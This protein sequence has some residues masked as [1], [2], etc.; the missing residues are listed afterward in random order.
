VAFKAEAIV[1]PAD[2]PAYLGVGEHAGRVSDLAYHNGL[3]V[4]VWSMLASGEVKVTKQ[5]KL[6]NVLSSG[7][8]FGE[9]AY[10]SPERG[11]RMAAV[12]AMGEG[13]VIVVG[14]EA[15]AQATQNTRH[16][17]DRAFLR[18]LVDRLDLANTRLTS[19][20]L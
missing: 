2:L 4:Q 16:Q 19:L 8:C 9:M 18:I 12:S 13:L 20:A 14:T 15:L 3:M 6:L 5:N 7:E 11:A 10:L 1:G 17:F